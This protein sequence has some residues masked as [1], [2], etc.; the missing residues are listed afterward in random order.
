M[1]ELI[2]QLGIDWKVLIAQGVNFFI[3]LTVLSFLVY[4]PLMR[5]IEERRKKIEFGLEGAKLAEHRLKEIDNLKNEKIAEAGREAMQII[6]S[7]EED[8]G[9]EAQNIINSAENK[10]NQLIKEGEEITE[11]R[12][13]EELEKLAKESSSL[14]REAIAKA[15]NLDS[16]KI[17]E[18]LIS[19][20]TDYIKKRI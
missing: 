19:Q 10:A 7:A 4:R 3:L 11:N 18:A 16:K 5:L 15:V 13:K 2:H 8:A 1:A 20:A 6:H 17:D 12:K 14:I 9:K